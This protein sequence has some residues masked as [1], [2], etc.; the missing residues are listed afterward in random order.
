MLAMPKLNFQ[1]IVIFTYL[2]LVDQRL[3][4]KNA[5][6]G[7]IRIVREEGF[8]KLFRGVEWSIQR[9]SLLSVGQIAFYDTTKNLLLRTG[10]F[11]DTVS[12]H[13]TGSVL[14]GMVATILTQP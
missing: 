11:E 10:W 9:A 4:Y 8:A 7:H 3:N 1:Y 6:D 13:L 12:T 14:A 5:I 2:F